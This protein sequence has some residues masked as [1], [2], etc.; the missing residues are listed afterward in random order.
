MNVEDKGQ[1]A[2]G[3]LRFE[4]SDFT[5]EAVISAICNQIRA[6]QCFTSAF[7]ILTSTSA[8]RSVPRGLNRRQ[9]LRNRLLPDLRAGHEND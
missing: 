8:F 6:V 9:L 2:E 3:D 1:N 7:C 4:I 5:C